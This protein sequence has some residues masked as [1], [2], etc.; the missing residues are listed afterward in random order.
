MTRIISVRIR[1]ALFLFE[2]PFDAVVQ[3]VGGIVDSVI[4]VVVD[5]IGA[6]IT[7]NLPRV[8]NLRLERVPARETANK[9]ECFFHAVL[10]K[11]LLRKR[12]AGWQRLQSDKHLILAPPA[13][14]GNVCRNR[15]A[16][17]AVVSQCVFPRLKP[18]VKG[19]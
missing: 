1:I 17:I 8:C 4:D 19:I 5:V 18:W 2:P 6:G 3:L 9:G 13:A 7:G 16:Q 14:V 12:R 11:R 10:I 15:V